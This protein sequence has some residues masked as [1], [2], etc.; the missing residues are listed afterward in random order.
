VACP[1]PPPFPRHRRLRSGGAPPRFVILDDGWQAVD[2]GER[3]RQGLAFPL[4][5]LAAQ[6]LKSIVETQLREARPHAP[7]PA[8]GG[9]ARAPA[10]RAARTSAV[11]SWLYRVLIEP[12][13]F[14]SRAARLWRWASAGPLR[15]RLIAFFDESTDFSKSL[16]S[17][18]PNSKFDTAGS[19]LAELVR[20]LKGPTLGVETVYCWHALGG[21]WSGISPVAPEMASLRPRWSFPKPARDLLL[22]E[23]AVAW[24]PASF[25]GAG[26]IEPAAFEAFFDGLHAQLAAAGVSGVKVDAQSGLSPFGAGFGIGQ[27]AYVREAVHAMEASVRRH[28]GT[29]AGSAA[30]AELIGCMCHSSENLLSF[31]ESAVVRAGD[32]F[33]PRDEASHAAHISTVAYNSLF[34]GELGVVD[35]DM[36]QSAHPHASLHAAARAVSGGAIY[37]SDK[38]GE[39]NFELLRALVLP[40]G[41]TLRPRHAGRC[42]TRGGQ[43]GWRGQDGELERS[44]RRRAGALRALPLTRPA[45]KIPPCLPLRPTVD[46]LFADVNRDG[47]SALKIWNSNADGLTGL[48][49]AFNVQG[50]EWSRRLRR[51]VKARHR[52]LHREPKPLAL[53]I[54][55]AMVAE[56]QFDVEGAN[57][58]GDAFAYAIFGFRGRSLRAP[59]RAREAVSY[60]PLAAGEF[61]LFTVAP[62]EHLRTPGMH[63]DGL[64]PSHAAHAGSPVAWAALGLVEMMNGGGAL[65]ERSRDA[66]GAVLRARGQGLFG[67]YASRAPVVV[68]VG[69]TAVGYA[70]DAEAGGLLTFELARMPAPGAAELHDIRVCFF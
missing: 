43:S 42:A 35:W 41:S 66:R 58:F 10:E 27:P 31:R 65:V 20:E 9:A 44:V 53:S 32:D 14:D 51:F 3:D 15:A 23:P 30:S 57:S 24:D 18:R 7:A 29:S 16:V 48:L 67:L 60:P 62:I 59:V 68:L 50:S 34:L 26:T 17:F 69:G 8:D 25:N 52:W 46:C 47:V 37:V 55:P 19:S 5:N 11:A 70:Y 28:F 38:P 1:A 6:S 63:D 64:I 4:P 45:R 12:A 2:N 56:R 21:Y 22:V 39:H 36:F 49:G 40:D 54:S 13:A 33:Y 61:E